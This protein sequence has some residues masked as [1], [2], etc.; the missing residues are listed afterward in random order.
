MAVDK[1]ALGGM[2]KHMEHNQCQYSHISNLGL[3]LG[4]DII[5]VTKTAPEAEPGQNLR[6]KLSQ[7]QDRTR[8][9]N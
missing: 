3:K 5:W 8:D 4:Q 7:S 2:L 9:R 6:Q 1:G